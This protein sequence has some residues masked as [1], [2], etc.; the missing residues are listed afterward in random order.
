MEYG[1]VVVWLLTYLLLL[2]AGMPLAALVLPQLGDQGAGV[3]LPLALAVVWLPAFLVGH[4]S[5]AASLWVGLAA[6]VA[7][8]AAARW[9]GASIDRR[10]YAEV[11]TVFS[12]AFLFLVAVRAVDPAIHPYGGEKFLDYGLVKTVLRSAALPPEDMWFAG[13]PVMYYYGGHFLT[14]LLAR[15]TGTAPRFAYNLALAGFYAAFVT[16]AYGLAGSI[17]GGSG[18]FDRLAAGLG[19]FFVGFASNLT[20]A[21]ALV[22]LVLP[23]GAGEW[24]ATSLNVWTGRFDS[25]TLAQGAGEFGAWDATGVIDG[26][27]NEFPLFAWLNGDLHGHMMAP[28]FTLLAAAVLYAVASTPPAARRRRLALLFGVLPALGGMIA[29]LNTWSFPAVGGL[30]VLTFALGF[31]D[32]GTLVPARLRRALGR[33][34]GPLVATDSTAGR[35]LLRLLGSLCLAVLVVGLA[36]VWSL[37]F[38]LIAGG[39]KSVAVLGGTSASGALFAVHGAF[40]LAFGALFAWRLWDRF[41]IGPLGVAAAGLAVAVGLVAT[42]AAGVGALVLVA[43]FVL[44]GWLLARADAFS[45]PAG[46]AGEGVDFETV[47]IVGG[48]GLV[49]LVEVVYLRENAGPGRLNTVF[50]VYAQVWALW[51]VAAGASLARLVRAPDRSLPTPRARSVATAFVALL[52]VATSIYG[53]L[54]LEGHVTSPGPLQRVDDPTLDGLDYVQAR[55]PGEAPAI[56]WV[57]ARE[58]QPTVLT[59][60]GRQIYAWENAPSSLTGVPTVIG[61]VHHERGFGRETARERARDVDTIYTGAPATQRALLAQYDVEYVYVGPEERDVYDR[62]TVGN[63]STTSVAARPGDVVIYAVGDAS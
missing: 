22:A 39:G 5:V 27:I 16:A 50:K 31:A 2:L 30:T 19:G 52:V 41:R 51:S 23:A 29:V 13:E 36:I 8:V 6:L 26:T 48:A 25:P 63:L 33:E 12:L 35:E 47:L 57:E 14:G 40:L 3:A 58:G 28:A 62:I 55:H 18:R 32:P 53:V 46:T 15:L 34:D 10:R 1:L 60:P 11:A 45:L 38:W 4:V 24:L 37:P 59:A 44:V 42:S 49:C 21:L 17:A 56:D 61:W 7:A 54:A 20:T 43:P 9:A